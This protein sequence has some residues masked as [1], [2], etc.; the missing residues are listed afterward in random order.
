MKLSNSKK[1]KEY[2]CLENDMKLK[3]ESSQ[4]LL[5]ITGVKTNQKNIDF[6]LEPAFICLELFNSLPCSIQEDK[7]FL[8]CVSWLPIVLL[9]CCKKACMT[10]CSV[11]FLIFILNYAG[12]NSKLKVAPV[13][14]CWNP[15]CSLFVFI[16]LSSSSPSY[17]GSL[18]ALSKTSL[19][20]GS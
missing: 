3:P 15:A 19:K 11:F 2:W 18:V 5:W 1:Y 9:L 8:P 17:A 4:T 16:T 10:F 14:L 12:G 7:I 13:K 6:A 20:M